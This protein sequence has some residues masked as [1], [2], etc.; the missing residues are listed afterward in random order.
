MEDEACVARKKAGIESLSLEFLDDWAAASLQAAVGTYRKWTDCLLNWFFHTAARSANTS[1][2]TIQMEFVTV[3][4]P[5]YPKLFRENTWAPGDV[6]FTTVKLPLEFQIKAYCPI[7][8]RL[9]LLYALAGA[10]SVLMR[11][12]I[13]CC[14]Q[15]MK[16][17]SVHNDFPNLALL[18]LCSR[19]RTEHLNFCSQLYAVRLPGCE[20]CAHQWWSLTA[21]GFPHNLR[22]FP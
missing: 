21:H 10:I 13:D 15:Q 9:F 5:D 22:D 11:V 7:E 1:F 16:I 19:L 4:V 8:L 20:S 6:S 17:N 14:S 12:I 2:C 18:P 3:P